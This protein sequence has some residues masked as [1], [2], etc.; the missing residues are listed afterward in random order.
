MD[1]IKIKIYDKPVDAPNYSQPE[2]KAATLKSVVVVVNGTVEGNPTV[3][4]VF[5][6]E[7]GQKHV[8]LVKGSFLE[9]IGNVVTEKR[10]QSAN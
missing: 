8:V 3:D 2:Y 6:D 1:S 10:N 4:L 9:A 7:K 5:R